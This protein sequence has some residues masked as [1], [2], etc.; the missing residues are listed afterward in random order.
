M[1]VS[2]AFVWL[3]EFAFTQIILEH[4]QINY[5]VLSFISETL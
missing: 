3:G 4:L 5:S 1:L 2:Q